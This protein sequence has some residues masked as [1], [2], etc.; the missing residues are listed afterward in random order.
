[1]KGESMASPVTG[2]LRPRFGLGASL[3]CGVSA[4]AIGML[5]LAPAYAQDAAAQPETDPP[6]DQIQGMGGGQPTE[7]TIS[8]STDADDTTDDGPIIVTGIRQ[9]LQNSQNIK[10]NSDT[11]VDAI[12][13]LTDQ[14]P[15]A[16]VMMACLEDY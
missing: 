8:S 9:S 11:V 15:N 4:L 13:A 10:R 12:T 1:M 16:V 14:V 3:R 2:G 7:G 5:S 6:A